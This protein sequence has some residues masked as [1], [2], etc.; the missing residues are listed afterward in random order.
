MAAG[1]LVRRHGG[2]GEPQLHG[3][4]RDGTRRAYARAPSNRYT[5]AA[6]LSDGHAS[7]YRGSLARRVLR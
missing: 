6:I 1:T 5:S 3:L 2:L 7:A 4:H